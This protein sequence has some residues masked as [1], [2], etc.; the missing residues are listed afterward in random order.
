MLKLKSADLEAAHQVLE[1]VKAV[2]K[3]KSVDVVGALRLADPERTGRMGVAVFKNCIRKLGVGLTYKE[4]DLLIKSKTKVADD[5][6][7]LNYES[8]LASI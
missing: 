5:G 6:S 2:S 4:V 1:K 3:A 8:F 7:D